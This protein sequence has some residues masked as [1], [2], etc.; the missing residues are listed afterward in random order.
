M[1]GHDPQWIPVRDEVADVPQ[2]TPLETKQAVALGGVGLE[3]TAM[4]ARQAVAVRGEDPSLVAA[5]STA[6]A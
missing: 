3:G 1:R 4:V 6:W 2:E 5:S